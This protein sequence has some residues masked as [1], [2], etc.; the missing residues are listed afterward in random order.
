MPMVKQEGS[1]TKAC[2]FMAVSEIRVNF[3]SKFGFCEENS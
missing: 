3:E 2:R 1:K